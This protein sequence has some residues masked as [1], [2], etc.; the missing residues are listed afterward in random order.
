M[1]D[2]IIDWPFGAGGESQS[3]FTGA[4]DRRRAAR[5]RLVGGEVFIFVDD[6]QRFRL[7]LRDLASL[8]MSGLSDAPLEI[9]QRVIVQLEEMLMPAAEVVWTRRAMVGLL[10]IN[11]L[12]LVRMKRLCE[13]HEA[14]AAW[15]PAMRAGSDLHSWWTDVAAQADGR[16]TRLRSGG[17]AHP[18]PR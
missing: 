4:E 2:D 13:R 3:E 8:G 5:Y 6:D 11:A 12:P 9:G 18:I 7:R 17:H 16:R 10:F 14:G 1:V 15:S